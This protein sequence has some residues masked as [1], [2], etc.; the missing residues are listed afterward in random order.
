MTAYCDFYEQVSVDTET[1]RLRPDMIV[2]LPNGR[3]IV[4][5]CKGAC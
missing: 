2:R 1:G 5:G 4:V 3:E